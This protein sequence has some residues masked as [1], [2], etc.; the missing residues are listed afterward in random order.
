MK[1]VGFLILYAGAIMQGMAFPKAPIS[2]FYVWVGM[3]MV[4]IGSIILSHF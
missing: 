4:V 1:S 3:P 2:L